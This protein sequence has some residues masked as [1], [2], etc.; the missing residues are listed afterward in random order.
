MNFIANYQLLILFLAGKIDEI[1]NNK[2]NKIR[3]K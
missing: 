1:K 3:T 2:K